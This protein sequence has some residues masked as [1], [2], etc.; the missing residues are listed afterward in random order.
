MQIS[1]S[2]LGL[3][4]K[5][6]LQLY[7]ILAKAYYL[8]EYTS[9]AITREYLLRYCAKEQTIFTVKKDSIVRHHFR[10]RKF[11]S[12]ELLKLVEYTL[13]TQKKPSIGLDL[14]NLPDQDWL[15][16]ILLH[17]DKE[18]PHGLLDPPPI[19]NNPSFYV[20]VNQE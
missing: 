19:S 18:D 3:K 16:N 20:D 13:K 7:N 8:P 6:S 11:S 15:R 14:L 12:I 1:T 17:L 10:Y 4:I 5:S 2:E 9:K